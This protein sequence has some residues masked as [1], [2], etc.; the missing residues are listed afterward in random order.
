MMPVPTEPGVVGPRQPIV[1]ETNSDRPF[2]ATLEEMLRVPI[3]L[4][5]GEP[6][7]TVFAKEAYLV[8]MARLKYP[9]VAR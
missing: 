9:L 6:L 2:R 4:P 5:T 7:A 3:M 1:F 8:S